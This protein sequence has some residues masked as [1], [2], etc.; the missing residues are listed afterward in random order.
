MHCNKKLRWGLLGTGNA[1]SVMAQAINASSTSILSAVASRSKQK[2]KNFSTK[3]DVLNYY[4]SYEDLLTDDAID[5]VCIALPHN[6][7]AEWSIKAAIAKKHI[8]C[9]KPAAIN[10]N[11]ASQVID[12]VIKNDVFYMEGFMYRCHAQTKKLIELLREEAI[13]KIFLIEASFCYNGI[14]DDAQIELKKISGGG[15]ILDV[16]CYPISMARLIASIANKVDSIRPFEINGMAH[17]GSKSMSDD[18]AVAILRFQSDIFAQVS[19]GV[20]LE[21]RNDVR[22][23]GSKGSIH[24]PSP[25]VPG[26]SGPGETVIYLKKT[27][28]KEIQELKVATTIGLYEQEINTVAKNISNRQ[29]REVSHQD[30]LDNMATLELWRE[31]IS[32]G[33]TKDSISY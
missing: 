10:A 14:F 22:I 32:L 27:G 28:D 29:A 6:L 19:C 17:I 5:A 21:H 30:T 23:F 20:S 2:A 31:S 18:Y 8:L 26:G 12:A 25:W 24:I 13:G 4:S 33:H 11:S 15:G 7:H 9:E 3:H 16:G 1:A